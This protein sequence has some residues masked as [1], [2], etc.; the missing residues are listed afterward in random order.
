[1]NWTP[2]MDLTRITNSR[3]AGSVRVAERGSPYDESGNIEDLDGGATVSGST[4]TRAHLP[5][6]PSNDDLGRDRTAAIPT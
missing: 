1:M 4:R 3:W 2:G 6:T 5:A